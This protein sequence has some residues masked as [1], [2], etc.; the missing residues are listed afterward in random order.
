MI[1]GKK[2]EFNIAEY[3][4]SQTTLEQIF[5]TF[6][7]TSIDEKAS[8]AFS[9]NG[10]GN[11]TVMDPNR[12]STYQKRKIM[13]EKTQASPEIP[14][15][16]DMETPLLDGNGHNENNYVS[17]DTMNSLNNFSPPEESKLPYIKDDAHGS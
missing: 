3:A 13:P 7:L 17:R 10:Q 4:V 12:L 9:Q 11:L 15:Q 1:E 8:L 14:G 6:A 5:Q 2:V 16:S